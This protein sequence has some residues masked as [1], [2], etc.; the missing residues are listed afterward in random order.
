MNKLSLL[1]DLIPYTEGHHTAIARKF[2]E[3]FL[4][5]FEGIYNQV[6]YITTP[7]PC[8]EYDDD[9]T[10]TV[11]IKVPSISWRDLHCITDNFPNIK[12]CIVIADMLMGISMS[13]YHWLND[14][15]PMTDL[16]VIICGNGISS[17][18]LSHWEKLI[19]DDAV[20]SYYFNTSVI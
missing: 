13:A 6:T 19:P 2:E 18:I 15:V 7:N 1:T 9:T 17:D 14:I 20:H 16:L 3:V 4:A 5:T 11:Y 12:R 10:E 8:L